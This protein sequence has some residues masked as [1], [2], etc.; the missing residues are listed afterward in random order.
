[1][2]RLWAIAFKVQWLRHL[3][4]SR[5]NSNTIIWW[6][7]A[8]R[9]VVLFSPNCE[10]VTIKCRTS[11]FR[12]RPASL[13]QVYSRPRKIRLLR[14]HFFKYRPR[15]Q[16]TKQS[17]CQCTPIKST[18]SSPDKLSYR[19]PK[20]NILCKSLWIIRLIIRNNLSSNNCFWWITRSMSNQSIRVPIPGAINHRIITFSSSIEGSNQLSR[21]NQLIE[22][23]IQ[24]SRRLMIRTNMGLLCKNLRRFLPRFSKTKVHPSQMLKTKS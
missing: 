19:C 2:L 10:E 7:V 12:V 14:V 13:E 1:M 17:C 15:P 24:N 16:L 20:V 6:V 18:S 5:T 23:R 22:M 3:L 4:F 21:V 8:R 11:A 9:L